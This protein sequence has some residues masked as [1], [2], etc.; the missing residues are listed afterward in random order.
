MTEN[1]K[2]INNP[3]TIIA[4]FAALAEVNATIAIG[5]I[6]KDLHYIFI[7]FIIG[8]PSILVILFF[9]TL[10]LNTK[11]MYSPS[12]YRED[13]TFL[14]SLYGQGGKKVSEKSLNSEKIVKTLTEFEEKVINSIEKKLK[15]KSISSDEIK[16]LLVNYKD[17][18]KVISE[19]AIQESLGINFEIPSILKSAIIYWISY[20]A[21][22]PIVYAIVKESL[23]SVEQIKSIENKYNMPSRWDI[24]GLK[25]LFDFEILIGTPEAFEIN[26]SVKEALSK[27]IELNEQTIVLIINAFKNANERHRKDTS[28]VARNISQRLIV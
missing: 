28:D 17:E 22:I 25:G 26:E 13:K 24:S 9:L 2:K 1:I 10:N 12:D 7:W 4:I 5:L 18:A 20:P 3:L 14:D 8:F 27:W 21:Y 16:E 19:R 23:K 11:V 6:D 15:Y